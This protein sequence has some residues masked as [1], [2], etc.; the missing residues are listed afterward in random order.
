[1][2]RWWMVPFLFPLLHPLH[3][4]QQQQQQ[5]RGRWMRWMR[6]W[7]HCLVICPPSCRRL[8]D[9]LRMQRTPMVVGMSHWWRLP[10]FQLRLSFLIAYCPCNANVPLALAAVAVAVEL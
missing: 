7:M 10:W 4:Q 2:L 6:L 3:R 9:L 5:H 8:V 1:M